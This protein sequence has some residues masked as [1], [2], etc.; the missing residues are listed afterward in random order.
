MLCERPAS[1]LTGDL[2]QMC[3]AEN[4]A[5]QPTTQQLLAVPKVDTNQLCFVAD[6]HT[7]DAKKQQWQKK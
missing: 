5:A 3:Q 1:T 2:W 4:L 7:M 6:L